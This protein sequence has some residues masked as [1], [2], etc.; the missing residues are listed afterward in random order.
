MNNQHQIQTT[1][2][3]R[4]FTLKSHRGVLCGLAITPDNRLCVTMSFDKFNPPARNIDMTE[5]KAG[6][7]GDVFQR[8][9][10]VSLGDALA[11]AGV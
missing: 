3:L 7:H 6:K 11:K 9:N 10:L 4:P 2:L 8:R 5:A 1:M